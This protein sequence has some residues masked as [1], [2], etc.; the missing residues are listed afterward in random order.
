MVGSIGRDNQS[1]SRVL[2]QFERSTELSY[3]SSRILIH[4]SSASSHSG[5]SAELGEILEPA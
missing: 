2:R 5:R 1:L 3:N 4:A